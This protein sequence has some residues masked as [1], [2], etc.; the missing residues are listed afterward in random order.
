MKKSILIALF[1]FIIAVGGGAIGSVLTNP[2]SDISSIQDNVKNLFE[3]DESDE[4][5]LFVNLEPFLLNLRKDTEDNLP[6]LK[7]TLSIGI[8]G[9]K[10]KALFEGKLDVVRDKTLSYLRSKNDKT[11]TEMGEDELVMKQELKEVLNSIFPE[12]DNIVDT[13]YITDMVMQ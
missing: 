10:N 2:D 13:I 9:E 5:V 4:P 6:Y 8:L 12:T 3:K 11:L 1:V 7:I